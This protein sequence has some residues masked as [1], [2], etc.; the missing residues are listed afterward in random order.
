MR[1][2]RAALAVVALM[3]MVAP[4]QFA[5]VD[6]GDAGFAIGS[7][8]SS[9]GSGSHTSTRT[10]TFRELV[11]EDPDESWQ[12]TAP[13]VIL[14]VLGWERASHRRAR[15]AQPKRAAHG[16]GSRLAVLVAWLVMLAVLTSDILSFQERSPG[17]G[18]FVLM[19]AWFAA[20]VGS[21]YEL[22]VVRRYE[23]E[24]RWEASVGH[25]TQ[26]PPEAGGM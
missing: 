4:V 10:L 18:Q 12:T 14:G 8:G 1:I 22:A 17:G 24:L 2:T 21:V 25:A 16:A 6:Q 5:R 23:R 19:C 13:L 20:I 11:S 7:H 3:C 26:L 9:A 15:R